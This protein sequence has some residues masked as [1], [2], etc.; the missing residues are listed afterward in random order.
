MNRTT[1]QG[2]MIFRQVVRL[3]GIGRP[4]TSFFYSTT[5]P[6]MKHTDKKSRLDIILEKTPTGKL[7]ETVVSSVY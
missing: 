1:A 7:D 6:S 2:R 3:T 4:N 5:P